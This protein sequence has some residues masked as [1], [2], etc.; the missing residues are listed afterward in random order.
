VLVENWSALEKEFANDPIA[1]PI[2]WG[3]NDRIALSEGAVVL[4]SVGGDERV[5]YLMTERDNVRS[6]ITMPRKHPWLA[7]FLRNLDN[8]RASEFSVSDWLDEYDIDLHEFREIMDI[9]Y[10]CGFVHKAAPRSA[11]PAPAGTARSAVLT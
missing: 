5:E 8:G 4:Q 2:N 6:S 10:Q 11:G 3:L 1:P 7:N 9:L